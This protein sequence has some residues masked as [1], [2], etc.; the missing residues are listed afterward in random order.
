ML[1]AFSLKAEQMLPFLL[2]QMQHTSMHEIAEQYRLL[3]G[4]PIQI[5]ILQE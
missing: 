4:M 5:A 3:P 2:M 1:P